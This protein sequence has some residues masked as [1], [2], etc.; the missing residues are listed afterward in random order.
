MYSRNLPFSNAINRLSDDSEF[1]FLGVGNYLTKAGEKKAGW[2]LPF[3]PQGT[4]P[5]VLVAL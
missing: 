2:S 4:I 1:L 5:W 3:A